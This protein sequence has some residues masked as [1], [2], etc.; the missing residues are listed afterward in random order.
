MKIISDS[1]L[2]EKFIVKFNLREHVPE[3]IVDVL[4]LQRFQSGEYLCY[5]EDELEYF[6]MLLSGKLQVDLFN[7]GG[8]YAVFSF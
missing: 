5:Q 4:A 2:R 8:N 1:V 7:F 3:I 6:Y